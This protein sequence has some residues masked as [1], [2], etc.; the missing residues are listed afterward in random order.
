MT[1]QESAEQFKEIVWCSL[2]GESTEPY[3]ILQEHGFDIQ[4]R[5]LPKS[6][7]DMVIDV[8]ET[9]ES[10]LNYQVY[11]FSG[12]EAKWSKDD[13]M[14]SHHS[15][16]LQQQLDYLSMNCKRRLVLCVNQSSKRY[17][18]WKKR[19]VYDAQFRGV[20]ATMMS[21]YPWVQF[22]VE[23]TLKG[24]LRYLET[25]I[26]NVK[27]QPYIHVT[28]DALPTKL[29][30]GHNIKSLIQI[31][32]LGPKTAIKILDKY[33]SISDIRYQILCGGKLS[34]PRLSS[35]VERGIYEYFSECE[36]DPDYL[37]LSRY[38]KLSEGSK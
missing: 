18:D 8:E 36:G 31:D 5:N 10:I 30:V 27:G 29:K 25:W 34:I 1:Q 37:K 2:V 32:G 26:K 9:A 16:H 4:Q 11:S 23:P 28:E 38:V 24:A 19:Q 21:Q 3:E 15:G 13:L 22:W 33:P 20:C 14:N 17:R 6:C 12:I 7:P 35:K